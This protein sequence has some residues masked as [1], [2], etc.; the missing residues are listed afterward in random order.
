MSHRPCQGVTPNVTPG[1][2][3]AGGCAGSGCRE[4]I[5]WGA[6]WRKQ[7]TPRTDA[8]LGRRKAPGERIA[9]KMCDPV[10]RAA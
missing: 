6:A 4:R 8:G 3:G 5:G 10:M 7:A 9:R 1:K 2:A